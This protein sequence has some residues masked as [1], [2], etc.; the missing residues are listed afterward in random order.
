VIDI[1]AYENQTALPSCGAPTH[2]LVDN[3]TSTSADVNWTENGDATQWEIEYGEIGFVQGEGFTIIDDDG[4]IGETLTDLQPHTDY[5]IYV[6]SICSETESDWEGPV[7]FNT[8]EMGINELDNQI[9]LYPNPTTGI[10]NLQTHKPIQ[11]VT[12]Y[13][14]MG[15]KV[16]YSLNKEKTS[17]DISNLSSGIYFV[18]VILNDKTIKRHKV[19]KK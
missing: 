9:T 10:I 16:S 1:G 13:N 17:I 6:R 15:Q 11:D 12:V 19:I 14:L 2:V 5:D 8:E 18:E 7:T 4:I 3:V